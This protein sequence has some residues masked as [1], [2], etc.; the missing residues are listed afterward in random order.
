M[1]GIT[2]LFGGGGGDRGGISRKLA[3][4]EMDHLN[5]TEP[6][7][8]SGEFFSVTHSRNPPSPSTSG[9]R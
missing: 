4:N 6:Y 7:G 1:W 2:C 5:T 3:A 9:D 8:E